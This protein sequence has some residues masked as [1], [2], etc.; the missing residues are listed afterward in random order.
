MFFPSNPEEITVRFCI[1]ESG[2]PLYIVPQVYH[3]PKL[4]VWCAEHYANDS[5]SIVTDQLS[6]IFITISRE[7]IIKMLGIH[8]VG[9]PE[10]NVITLLEEIL[11]QKLTSSS[12]QVQLAFVQGIQRPEYITST[13]EFPIKVDTFPTT[14]QQIL[15][16]YSQVFGLYYDQSF[17]YA[18]L[19]FLMYLSESVKFNYPKLIAENI[20]E[21]FSNFN[22]LTSFKYQASLMYLILDNFSLHF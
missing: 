12:P 14:I 2:L 6:Q 4:V 5:K 19:S 11:V 1:W 17:S 20:N 10:Q 18:F 21:Q 13:L 22:T 15:S 3:F 9:F 16:M 7:N 8:T